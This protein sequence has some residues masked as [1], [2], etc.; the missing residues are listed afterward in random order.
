MHTVRAPQ[1]TAQ[2][3]TFEVLELVL[4]LLAQGSFLLELFGQ[5]VELLVLALQLGFHL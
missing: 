4:V 5:H 3:Y 2:R 1:T